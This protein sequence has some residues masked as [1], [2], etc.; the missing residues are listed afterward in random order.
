MKKFL[1]VCCSIIIVFILIIFQITFGMLY[2]I[3]N[4]IDPGNISSAVEKIDF[5]SMLYDENGELSDFGEPI[6]EALVEMGFKRDMS[7]EILNTSSLKKT[8]GKFIG[9]VIEA[10]LDENVEIE[11]P[12][13]DEVKNVVNECYEIVSKNNILEISKEEVL[14]I[15]DDNYDGYIKELGSFSDDII[16]I[17]NSE[18]VFNVSIGKNDVK[19]IYNI[20]G[21][22]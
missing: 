1:N 17:F 3:R 19:T 10:S 22:E 5:A 9:S 13:K 20:R 4:T 14:K 15:I 21:R 11:F 2:C 12:T 8:L 16:E 6:T 7:K 18:S